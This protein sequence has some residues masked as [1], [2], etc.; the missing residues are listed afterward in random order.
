M[1][2]QVKYQNEVVGALAWDNRQNCGVF[3]FAEAFVQRGLDVAPI[4]MP[5]TAL[6]RGQRVFSFP[7]L[8]Q[9]TF[10]GLPGLL[11]DALPDAFGNAVLRAWLRAERRDVTSLSPLEKLSYVGKRAMGAFE[12]EPTSNLPLPN[13]ELEVEKLLSLTNKVLDAKNQ[14]ALDLTSD[15]HRAMATLIR[16]G[17]SAGGQRPKALI[18]Y[19]PET[20]HI[21]SGQVD[22]PPG[23]QYCLLKF[24]GVTAGQLGD[25]L[26]Y[27]RSELAYYH[28]AH[29]CGIEMMDS[30]LIEENGRAHFITQR[31]DRTADGKKL[32]TQT[33]CALSHFDFNIAGAYDY[34]DAFEEMR[35][36][37]LSYPEMEQFYRRMVFN[38]VARN[39]DDHTKNISFIMD[40]EGSWKLSPAYDVAW[41]YNPQGDWTNVHQMSVGGK[42]DN[43]R[44]ED[45][46]ALGKRQGIKKALDILEQTIEVVSKWQEF[47][48][49]TDVGPELRAAIGK[50]HRL[51]L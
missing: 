11:A 14:L 35:A 33:L 28:M 43:F 51:G 46:L 30:R 29:A 23:Y 34:E 44:R 3:E 31:F 50:S 39:Q 15:E 7:Q 21:R 6:Q 9:R 40:E 26:G 37:G 13:E 41:S 1:I 45:I 48:D 27:G 24:D 42:R 22:L 12:F 5:L 10:E 32:H 38:V 20:K 17:A 18:G 19:N 2:V 4:T 8:S 49:M 16:V 47:A 36:I 25:P